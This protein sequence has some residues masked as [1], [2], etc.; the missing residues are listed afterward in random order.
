MGGCKNPV[1]DDGAGAI[2]DGGQRIR[3]E[4]F[5]PYLQFLDT[6]PEEPLVEVDGKHGNA[7]GKK[8]YRSDDDSFEDQR[9]KCQIGEKEQ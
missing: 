8:V 4:P 9:H 3:D 2:A 6:F 1:Q 7:Y 5:F